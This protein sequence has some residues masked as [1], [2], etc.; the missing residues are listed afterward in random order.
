MHRHDPAYLVELAVRVFGD[1]R[2][3]NEWLDRP[4][5]QLGGRSPR[6]LISTKAGAHRVEELLA[7]I[8]DDEL[9]STAAE[10]RGGADRAGCSA[11]KAPAAITKSGS[12]T[13]VRIRPVRAIP[14]APTPPGCAGRGG[15]R[16]REC[17][18]GRRSRGTSRGVRAVVGIM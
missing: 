5:V 8:D 2:A 11:P 17:R 7:Q 13:P 6:A 10:A 18:S 1:P 4:S 3:A 15:A 16:S 14:A 9:P 12:A